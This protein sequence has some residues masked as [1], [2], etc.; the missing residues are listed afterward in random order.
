M[1][2]TISFASDNYSPAHPTIIKAIEHV[3]VGHVPAYGVDNYTQHAIN[4]FKKLLGDNID[5]YFVFNGTAANVIGLQTIAK[6]FNGIF[7]AS[8]AHIN[9]DECGAPEKHTGCKL[10]PIETQDGKLTVDAIKQHISRIG[11]HHVVQPKVISITQSTEYGTVYTPDEIKAIAQFAHNHNMLL[12]MDGA[13]I[14]NAVAYLNMD[15]KDITTNAGV[16]ILSFGG[17]KNGLIFG[18]ALIF[19]NNSNPDV[20]FYRK[21][22]L[23]LAS[24]M[25]FIAAQFTAL[26]HDNLWLTNARHA[27]EMA[28]LLVRGVQN[29]PEIQITQKV[30][31][32]AVFALMPHQLIHELQ[33]EYSFYIWNESTYEV[34]WMTA[35]DTKP[36]DVENFIAAL[37]T[38]VH[39]NK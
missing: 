26:L 5:V 13:R 32:N 8:T 33:K 31:A 3:N 36:E 1:M 4:A 27:N 17:T 22:S 2:N 23:N 10:L 18:E 15:I 14:S 34:R 38:I 6:S 21:Q 25:R 28:Q 9:V 11:D 16:D 39:K 7:C 12:H 35:F 19:F 24:K 30:Q 20:K 29:I 37:K